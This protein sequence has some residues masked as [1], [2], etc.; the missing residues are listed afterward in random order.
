M[1]TKQA[2]PHVCRECASPNPEYATRDVEIVRRGL[3]SVVPAVSGWFCLHCDEIEFDESTDS[4]QRWAAAGDAL[5]LRDRARAKLLGER[6]RRQRQRLNL[7]QVEAA[8]LAGGGPVTKR[9]RPCQS[10]P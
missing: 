5:V 2:A 4:L 10:L 8:V 7:N 6:L 3:K 1:S 9:A